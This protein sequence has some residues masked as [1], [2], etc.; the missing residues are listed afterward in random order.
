MAALP[1]SQRL[2]L[3]LHY[4]QGYTTVEITDLMG[5]NLYTLSSVLV[6]SRKNLKIKL[7]EEGYGQT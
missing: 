2:A 5:E 4:Y 3:C 6:L 7:E 1:R